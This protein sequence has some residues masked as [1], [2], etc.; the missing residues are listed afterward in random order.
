MRGGT[1]RALIFREEELPKNKTLW[2]EFFMKALGV[3]KTAA[4]LSAMGV[5]FPT[6]KIVVL[7][8][9]EGDD[10]DVDYNF[11]QIDTENYYV[12]NRGNCGNMSSAVGPYAIDE[13]MVEAKEPETIVRIFNTNTQRI[14][15]SK[16][17]VKNGKS[18]I[19]GDTKI[20]GVPGTGSPIELTFENPS[21]GLTGK[22][23]PTG[24]KKDI[25]YIPGYGK[26]PITLI[27]CAN[28]V[29]IFKAEDAGLKG[30]ELME[31]NKNQKFM[32]LVTY[33]RGMSAKL[34]G[35]VDKWED[36]VTKSTYMPFVGIVSKPQ[37]YNDMDGNFVDKK[38]MSLCCRS[39]ITSMHRSYPIAA[40]IAT[41]AAARVPGTVANECV[42]L[43]NSEEDV[44]L[45]HAGGYTTVKIKTEGEQIL[46]GT[47]IRTA[48]P[49]MKGNLWVEI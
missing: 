32:N 23:F 16:I 9:H 49:I 6:H 5:D 18:C 30:T 46:S 34:C 27:D 26:L 44:I 10:A 7:S 36:A 2:P 33:V 15:K 25:L 28:P 20:H 8:P 39:F 13:G 43:G 31:L 45:G 48:C 37:S 42:S 1:S 17:R 22:V 19:E 47:V 40:S 14:I 38:E 29:V 35:L 3:R 24:N 21:G 41:A 12:D 4:G 11:F